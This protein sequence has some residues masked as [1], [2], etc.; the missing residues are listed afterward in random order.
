MRLV[1]DR[2]RGRD[3]EESRQQAD[4]DDGGEPP[5]AAGR[6]EAEQRAHAA[7]AAPAEREG[8]EDGNGAEREQE[9]GRREERQVHQ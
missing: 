9:A 3:P 4:R 7:G 1:D 2:P 8:G 6:A 5:L